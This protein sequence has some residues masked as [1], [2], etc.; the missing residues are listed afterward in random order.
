MENVNRRRKS[1]FKGLLNFSSL[2]LYGVDSF[3]NTGNRKIGCANKHI[4]LKVKGLEE[5]LSNIQC[6]NTGFFNGFDEFFDIIDIHADKEIIQEKDFIEP[7][8][9]IG[10]ELPGLE[11]AGHFFIE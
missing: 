8:R 3:G 1:S 10:Q 5:F 2:L 4:H 7:G 11:R 9:V 6:L